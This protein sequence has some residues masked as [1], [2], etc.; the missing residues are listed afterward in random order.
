MGTSL[1]VHLLKTTD[2]GCKLIL[3]GR[4]DFIWLMKEF[5]IVNPHSV[6]AVINKFNGTYRPE[7]TSLMGEKSFYSFKY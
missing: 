2:F 4:G 5:G 7:S 3:C 1:S 6:D